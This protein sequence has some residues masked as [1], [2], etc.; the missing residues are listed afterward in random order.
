MFLIIFLW[1]IAY[2]AT[3]LYLCNATGVGKQKTTTSNRHYLR[4]VGLPKTLQILKKMVT[5][6]LNSNTIIQC[7][8]CD[9]TS[10]VGDAIEKRLAQVEAMAEAKAMDVLLTSDQAEETLKISSTTRWRWDK[11]GYLTPIFIGGKRRYRRSDIMA[12]IE[13]GG[14]A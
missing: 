10:I 8:L 13:Q 14:R 3:P 5:N 11:S 1:G 12:L 7:S 2:D 4:A 6:G 9:L